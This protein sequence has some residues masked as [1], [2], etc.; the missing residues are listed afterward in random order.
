MSTENISIV[1]SPQKGRY[2]INYRDSQKS[3]ETRIIVTYVQ[4]ES[5]YDG[6]RSIVITRNGRKLALI[7]LFVKK[8]EREFAFPGPKALAS[9]SEKV[10]EEVSPLLEIAAD[11]L[12]REIYY[13]VIKNI[14]QKDPNVYEA[15]YYVDLGMAYGVE[16]DGDGI[17]YMS[18]VP[19]CYYYFPV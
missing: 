2:T 19:N 15:H 16:R 9:Q 5:V 1:Y 14:F 18:N 6:L 7:E 10:L 12:E 8:F 11:S 3:E 17:R 13:W 4:R